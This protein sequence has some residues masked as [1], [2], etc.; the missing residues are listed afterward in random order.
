MV[1]KMAKK[2][3][4]EDILNKFA[5][6]KKSSKTK[7]GRFDYFLLVLANPE[8]KYKT[9]HVAG[10]SGKGSTATFISSILANS[11]ARVG[12]NLSPHVELV[13]ER[14]QINNKP[15]SAEVF[16]KYLKEI[17]PLTREVES[18]VGPLSYFE[19]LTGLAFY[20]FAREKVEIAVIETGIGGS[21]D[22]T[23]VI[24]PEVAVLTNVDLDHTQVLGNTIEKI[25]RDKAG[26]IKLGIPVV[27]GV[28]QPSVQEIVGDVVS[29]NSSPLYTVGK[30]IQ[31]VAHTAT[32][33]GSVFS[34]N[35][36]W[37]A[38]QNLE[39]TLPGLFQIENATLALAAVLAMK[40]NLVTQEAIR[41]GLR[42]AYIPGR[43]EIIQK[44][45]PIVL[46]GAHNPAKIRALLYSVQK[47]FPD[48]EICVFMVPKKDR[49][50][51]QIVDVV[52]KFS[53]NITLTQ[54]EGVPIP[55]LL[56]RTTSY[57]QSKVGVA[58]LVFTDSLEAFEETKKMLKTNEV[59]VVTGSF[60]L[61]GEI[62]RK[63]RA[64]TS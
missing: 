52:T 27:T 7:K 9:I 45:P 10:T 36:P 40:N 46:D 21:R 64:V 32:P 44:D 22:V 5:R 20:I 12:L 60:Y 13:T 55:G 15:I 53:N 4:I 16:Y 19:V 54:L 6:V 30:E 59:L 41:N 61:V 49:D 51:A 23:N 26:I 24:T 29:K 14:I 56:A 62:K 39:I 42:K 48:K 8:S 63:G 34:A 28:T 31:Y 18:S 47:L 35:T 50:M 38:F 43:F 37:G 2:Q 33:A 17:L 11:G 1:N 25:A 3:L 57:F 58:P